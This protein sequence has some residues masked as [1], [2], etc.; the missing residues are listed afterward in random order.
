MLVLSGRT[1][2]PGNACCAG[3]EH[4]V[5]QRAVELLRNRAGNHARQQPIDR[6]RRGRLHLGQS[7]A[8]RRSQSARRGRECRAPAPSPHGTP[9]SRNHPPPVRSSAAD[10]RA[11]RRLPGGSRRDSRATA[12][13]ANPRRRHRGAP[14]RSGL[15]SAGWR[16]GGRQRT[17]AAWFLSEGGRCGDLPQSRRRARGSDTASVRCD[18]W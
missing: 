10:R 1:P 18:W 3:V 2:E 7:A 12:R 9:A 11:A 4:V 13:P 8:G 16:S 17:I 14:T 5:D 15:R 6:G